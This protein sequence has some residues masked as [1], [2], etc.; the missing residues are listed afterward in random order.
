MALAL[1]DVP[2]FLDSKNSKKCGDKSNKAQAK[3]GG[4]R[5]DHAT[6]LGDFALDCYGVSEEVL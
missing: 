1:V 3:L 4:K 6:L 2:L 5:K